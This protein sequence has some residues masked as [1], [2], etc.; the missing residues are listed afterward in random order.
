MSAPERSLA[1]DPLAQG[2][3]WRGLDADSHGDGVDRLFAPGLGDLDLDRPSG[4][5]SPRAA[6]RRRRAH[7]LS[8]M[9][10]GLA[11]ALALLLHALVQQPA[12]E[13]ARPGS[14]TLSEPRRVEPR[15]HAPRGRFSPLA[16]GDRRPS[17][18]PSRLSAVARPAP[19]APPH[20]E[21]VA[22][23]VLPASTPPS[24]EFGFEQ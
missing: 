9:G 24:A 13:E 21:T 3:D 22:A 14:V 15:R 17:T 23:P 20:S 6:A 1:D 19:T 12:S 5:V 4:A 8:A 18:R 16:R 10:A 7:A 11:V 2:A